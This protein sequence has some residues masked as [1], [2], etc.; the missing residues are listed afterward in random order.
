MEG[1]N[2]TVVL[3]LRRSRPSLRIGSNDT[4]FFVDSRMGFNAAVRLRFNG[5]VAGDLGDVFP[6]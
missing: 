4:T 5:R 3:A 2:I 1:Q 6:G